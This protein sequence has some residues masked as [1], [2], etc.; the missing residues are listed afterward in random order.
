MSGYYGPV[1]AWSPAFLPY[2]VGNQYPFP[3][4]MEPLIPHI[5]TSSAT[6]NYECSEDNNPNGG[7][8]EVPCTF[9]RVEESTEDR[10]NP[11]EIEDGSARKSQNVVMDDDDMVEEPKSGMKFNSLE[12]LTSYY[13]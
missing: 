2:P 12:D 5:S 11:W 1:P 4:G 7:E 9:P 8:T 6:S 10:S 13:K 3:H